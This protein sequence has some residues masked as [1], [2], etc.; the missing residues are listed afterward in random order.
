MREIELD[1]EAPVRSLAP[2]RIGEAF[3]GNY[4][5]CPDV[6][7]RCGDPG[8]G[9]SVGTELLP[10]VA[11]LGSGVAAVLGDLVLRTIVVPVIVLGAQ[12]GLGAGK[13]AGAGAVLANM[14]G[15]ADLVLPALPHVHHQ[16][17]A[18]KGGIAG[19]RLP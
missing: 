6:G 7:C 17:T 1:A 11:S 12:P 19:R 13:H 5:H 18:R 8:C 10:P 4:L 14:E 3:P 9:E 16:L 2:Q 15:D